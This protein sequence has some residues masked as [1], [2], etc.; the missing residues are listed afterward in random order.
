MDFGDW[1]VVLAP[2]VLISLGLYLIYS[3]KDQRTGAL[4]AFCGIG[5]YVV[6][7]AEVWGYWGLFISVGV[8]ALIAGVGSLLKRA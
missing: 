5:L 6:I 1:L 8:I 4:A 3:G 2:L 7:A